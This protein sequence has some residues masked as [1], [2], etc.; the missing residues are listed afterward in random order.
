MI[1]PDSVMRCLGESCKTRAACARYVAVRIQNLPHVSAGF[2]VCA[3]L[4]ADCSIPLRPLTAIWSSER[5][6][7]AGAPAEA[8]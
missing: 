6:W 4:D 7:I 8:A 3:R 5:G 2:N 1:N